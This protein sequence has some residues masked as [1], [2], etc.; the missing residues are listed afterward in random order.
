LPADLFE[1]TTAA[2]VQEKSKLQRHF[3]R[4]D[5]LFFLICTLVGLDTIGSVAGKGAQ[6]FTWLIFLAIFFFF[7]YALL[8]AELGSAFHE[9]GG[10]YI[11]TKLAFGRLTS[12]LIAVLYWISN[13]IWV[14]GSLAITA[15]TAFNVFFT[16]MGDTWKYVFALAFIWFTVASAIISFDKGKWIPTIGAWCRIL[17]LSFF[18]LSVVIYA[19]EHGVHGF[20]SSSY[21]PT[22]LAFILLVPVLV[23]N[24]VGFELP[25]S[26]GDEMTNPQKDVPFTVIRSA[27]GAVVLYG[28]PILAILLVLPAS[29][30]TSLSGFVTAIQQVFTVYGGHTT[31]SGVT[32]T[33]FGQFF[34]W[35]A[36]I[37]FIFALVTSG[38]TWIMGADRTLA[39]SAYDGAGPRVLG[40]FSARFGTPI[41]VNIL[42]GLASTAVMFLAFNLTSGNANKYF[43]VVLGLAISTTTVAYVFIFPAVVRLRYTHPDVPRPYRIPL[44]NIGAWICGSLTTLWAA[45]ATAALVWP[46]FG[47]GWFGTSGSA[48]SALASVNFAGERLQFELSQ[49]IPLAAIVLLGLVFYFSGEATREEVVTL[50]ITEDAPAL[51]PSPA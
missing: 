23:F 32:L 42:S 34:G 41:Y 39:V 19:G 44:G 33:G 17:V 51:E 29:A 40:T 20:A 46:G 25:N 24:Y 11:W 48:D 9:E 37:A 31:A 12:G 43:S 30:I 49:F 13:P 22:Y 15:I 10:A 50:P 14:G 3:K 45:L 5:M 47:I 2:A 21:K 1:E 36:S 38:S 18:T 6:A 28:A 35:L 4:F 26:A 7:P 16:N 8:I 27:V